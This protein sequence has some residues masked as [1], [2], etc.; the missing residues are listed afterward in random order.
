MRLTFLKDQS[1]GQGPEDFV[2]LLLIFYIQVS[3]SYGS[4]RPA[5]L[6]VSSSQENKRNMNLLADGGSR[7]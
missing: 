5:V 1:S 6:Q 3:S 4:D 2:S 7:C